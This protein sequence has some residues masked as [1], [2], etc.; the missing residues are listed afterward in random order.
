MKKHEEI[1]KEKIEGLTGKEVENIEIKSNMIISY[2]PFIYNDVFYI[3]EEQKIVPVFKDIKSFEGSLN[4]SF[5]VFVQYKDNKSS[6]YCDLKLLK[7]VLINAE[8]IYPVLLVPNN[9]LNNRDIE[10]LDRLNNKKKDIIILGFKSPAKVMHVVNLLAFDSEDLLDSYTLINRDNTPLYRIND[11][12]FDCLNN[13]MLEEYKKIPEEDL[14][15][16]INELIANIDIPIIFACM[17]NT[18][19]YN[20]IV[21]KYR[22]SYLLGK[23]ISDKWI[24]ALIDLKRKNIMVVSD[25]TIHCYNLDK[26]FKNKMKEHLFC[27]DKHNEFMPEFTPGTL[28]MD[29]ESSKKGYI[30]H[31]DDNGDIVAIF[32]E[33][34]GI[35]I[36][37]DNSAKQVEKI[38]KSSKEY[39]PILSKLSAKDFL[40]KNEIY[41][42]GSI[43]GVILKSG[44]V[45]KGDI[46]DGK[47]F[48]SSKEFEDLKDD[49]ICYVPKMTGDYIPSLV[50]DVKD[51][52]LLSHY[53]ALAYTK[54]SFLEIT[55][56]NKEQAAILYDMVEWEFP[57]SLY[58][59]LV[60]DGN[61][62]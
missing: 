3:S 44:R 14:K 35:P 55:N 42:E 56:Q 41:M 25:R 19:V 20:N 24:H 11:K 18:I 51:K 23:K 39:K 21:I 28:I 29:N 48:K 6:K 60:S 36:S 30:D 4:F 22:D 61:F 53:N 32:N 15:Y 50:K 40:D 10:I 62:K 46:N 8:V 59:A 33:F 43:G 16:D 2:I 9:E 5:I 1:I 54:E 31:I 13:K 37:N 58:A 45:I 38:Y 17:A 27:L 47:C 26:N 7:S 12:Y 52:S 34:N 49:E 57:E